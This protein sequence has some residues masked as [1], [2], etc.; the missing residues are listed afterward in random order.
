MCAYALF[1]LLGVVQGLTE[2]LPVSSSGH[3]VLLQSIAGFNPPGVTTEITLHIATLVAVLIYYRRDVAAL[4]TGKGIANL[5]MPRAYLAMVVL[6][7]VVTG[8]LVFPFREALVG[9]TQGRTALTA[10]AFTF[11]LTALFLFATDWMLR[12]PRARAGEIT[13]IGW[14]AAVFIAV[15]QAVAALPGVSRSGSTIFA[16]ITV[17]LKREEAA[18]FS[19]LLFIPI[20][21]LAVGMEVFALITGSET[22]PPNLWGPMAVGFVAALLSGLAAIRFLLVI[23]ERA[24]LSWFGIYL[25]ILAFASFVF[26]SI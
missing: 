7:T 21:L 5:R 24:R 19:F 1:L 2:F 11:S 3:L 16:G 10:L 26:S 9:L 22:V 25:I 4:L 15:V 14:L 13:S 6:A 23:L 17:G 20:T 12:R 18:R 8:C